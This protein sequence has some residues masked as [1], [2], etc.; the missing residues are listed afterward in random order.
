MEN[1]G[2]RLNKYLAEA[3]V[4]SRREA[5][6]LI[7]AGE[8]MIRRHSR[9]DEMPKEPERAYVGDRVFSGDTVY[10]RNEPVKRKKPRKVYY[11]F[12]KPKGIVCTADR[13]CPDNIVDYLSFEDRITYAGRLD[14]D[15][16]GLLILTNDG[17]LADDMMRASGAHEKEYLVTVDKVIT[18][19][20]VDEMSSGV[21]ICLDD[22]ETLRRQKKKT[23]EA[24]PKYVKTRPCRIRPVTEKKFRIVLTQ[25]YNRQIRRMCRA[26]GYEVTSLVRTR[27]MNVSLGEL[28]AG[29]MR[30]LTEEEVSELREAVEKK[31]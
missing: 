6:R 11:A 26:L 2:E 17:G 24:R 9:K 3:G 22:Q 4:C 19:S 27:V 23:G 5:D 13:S 31:R 12:N 29:Q 14:K 7:E 25:G 18:P 30:P 1:R 16:S 8:V 15:S 20:F 28:K 21:R 10:V